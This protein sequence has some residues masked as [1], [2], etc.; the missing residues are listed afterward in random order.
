MTLISIQLLVLFVNRSK[1]TGAKV[2]KA[3]SS[4]SV[5]QDLASSSMTLTVT[6]TTEASSSPSFSAR[7]SIIYGA[8]GAEL[9]VHKDP[10]TSTA[11]LRTCGLECDSCR[12]SSGSRSAESCEDEASNGGK[13]DKVNSNGVGTAAG[14]ERSWTIYIRTGQA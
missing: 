5:S 13:D 4:S 11:D 1:Q 3:D 9:V 6:P 10:R 12:I 2:R 7:R 14:V 8:E